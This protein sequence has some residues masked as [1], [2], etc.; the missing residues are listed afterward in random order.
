MHRPLVPAGAG[1]LAEDP[2]VF[3][4]RGDQVRQHLEGHGD[5]RA[6][7]RA[8]DVIRLCACWISLSESGRTSQNDSVKSNGVCEM[9]Q[10]FA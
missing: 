3:L 4:E 10:K 2:H 8:D 1:G 9:A 6:D 5:F 7:W